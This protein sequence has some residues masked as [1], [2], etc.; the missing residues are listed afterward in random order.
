MKLRAADIPDI[1]IAYIDT[2]LWDMHGRLEN[3]AVHSLIGKVRDRIRPYH[4]T[5]F[6]V[7]SPEDYAADALKVR[8]QGFAGYKIHPNRDWNGPHD[9]E[10]EIAIY[11]AVR[12]AVTDDW[13]LMADPFI[14]HEYNDARR[15]GKILDELDYY[16][17]ESPMPESDEY[18]AQYAHL[19]KEVNLPLIGGETS[20]GA[21]E[22][23]IEW[24]D[25]GATD[26]GRLD[27]FNGG[28]TSCFLLAIE[29]EKRG[30]PMDLHC[31][32][33]PHAQVFG[34]TTEELIPFVEGY[35]VPL[36]GPLDHEGM[37][38]IPDEVGVGNAPDEEVIRAHP[39]DWEIV[40][41]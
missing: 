33:H 6:N 16:W 19:R 41:Q 4:S 29:C 37:L 8:A 39:M 18:I 27:I 28:L 30:I 22:K 13:P 5:P 32:M 7:G 3:K 21:H 23:R 14:V 35:G 11:R 26:W 9:I 24:L 17:Y 40:E 34:A 12:E 10:Q 25:A 36:S 1:L 20:P 38:R 31:A 15:L 2:A